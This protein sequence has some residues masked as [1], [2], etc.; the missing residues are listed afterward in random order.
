LELNKLITLQRQDVAV[1]MTVAGSSSCLADSPL[2]SDAIVAINT[3]LE[4]AGSPLLLTEQA[5]ERLWSRALRIEGDWPGRW[6]LLVRVAE[7]A[8]LCAGNYADSCEF[9]AAGDFLVNPREIVIRYRCGGQSTVK[10]RHGRLSDQLGS[11]WA[12]PLQPPRRF[13]AG[14]DLEITR[15]PLLPLM[16]QTL[17]ES[18]RVATVFIRRLEDG[19][20]RIADVLAFM[21]GWRIHDSVE[22]WRRLKA[23]SPGERAFAESCMCRFGTRV[24]HRIGEE[25]QRS[26]IRSDYRSSFL[27]ESHVC[28]SQPA[29]RSSGALPDLAEAPA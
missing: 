8:L 9:S 12:G 7:A 26:L 18:G 27:S 5:V 4:I 22:L 13:S 23:S 28:G 3:D 1:S 15:P 29:C 11:A 2:P 24:F 20:R 16:T 21:S 17:K 6:L 10:N 25:L 19:Q 14:V